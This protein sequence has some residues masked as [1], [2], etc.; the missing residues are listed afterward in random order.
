M[1]LCFGMDPVNICWHLVTLEAF[2]KLVRKS[3]VDSAQ[4]VILRYASRSQ[5]AFGSRE[6]CREL[7]VSPRLVPGVCWGGWVPA[8]V[9]EQVL[10]RAWTSASG[11]M[12][13][14]AKEY[15]QARCL[16]PH[17]LYEGPP[18]FP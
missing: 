14:G 18:A 4:L 6:G 9:Q 2:E 8:S 3:Q 11:L 10:G 7:G 15:V 13:K 17:R 5:R 1:G 12:G 16:C